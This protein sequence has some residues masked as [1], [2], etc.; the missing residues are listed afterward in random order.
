L[1][2]G[3]WRVLLLGRSRDEREKSEQDGRPLHLDG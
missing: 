3:C 1:R 2:K